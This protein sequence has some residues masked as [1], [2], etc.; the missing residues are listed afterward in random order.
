[1]IQK[2]K[3]CDT[4]LRDGQQ[5][6]LATRLSLEDILSVAEQMDQ[7]GFYSMEVW[8]GA[9]FDSCMRFLNED[10]WERLR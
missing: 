5:S 2:V 6:L 8:G 9:T 10:P 3:I 4:T 7:I 1:M